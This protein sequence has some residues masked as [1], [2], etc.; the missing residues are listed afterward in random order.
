MSRGRH[1]TA[2][3]LQRTP[4]RALTPARLTNL[5]IFSGLYKIEK[6]IVYGRNICFQA[7][8]DILEPLCSYHKL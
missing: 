7:L 6:K 1:I 8:L 5:T 4:S 3:S 2:Y